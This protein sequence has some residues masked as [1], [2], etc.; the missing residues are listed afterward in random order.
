MR[1][2]Q[3]QRAAARTDEHDRQPPGLDDADGVEDEVGAL[4]VRDLA[5]R[6]T[7]L[8]RRRERRVGADVARRGATGGL[9][10]ERADPAEPGQ[11]WLL[12]IIRPIVPAPRTT[13]VADASPSAPAWPMRTA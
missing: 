7:H 6:V 12:R 9:R 4:A 5:N 10:L 8:V 11:Q 2:A 3:H 13:A 1:E